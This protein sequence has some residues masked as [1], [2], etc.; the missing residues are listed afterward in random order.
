MELTLKFS[1]FDITMLHMDLQFWDYRV[2]KNLDRMNWEISS[3]KLH[4][5]S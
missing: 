5:E 1:V 3:K 2:G 4:L